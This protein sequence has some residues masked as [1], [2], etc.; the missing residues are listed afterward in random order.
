[1]VDNM[2]IYSCGIG[3]Y[4]SW[5]G[6]DGADESEDGDLLFKIINELKL[7]N[8][9]IKKLLTTIL[10]NIFIDV[11]WFAFDTILMISATN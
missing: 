2:G 5:G 3:G 7:K 4:N 9:M 8:Y 6:W 10:E 1:M 11:D